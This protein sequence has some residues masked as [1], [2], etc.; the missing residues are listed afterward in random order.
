VALT[1][2]GAKVI[3]V[4]KPRASS[5]T[6]R[7]KLAAKFVLEGTVS[8]PSFGVSD[9]PGQVAA[10]VKGISDPVPLVDIAG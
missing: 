2:V 6:A 5:G 3:V 10:K 8:A 9:A 7:A 1:V 4:V